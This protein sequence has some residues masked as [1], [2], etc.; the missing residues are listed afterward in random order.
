LDGLV[1]RISVA[2]DELRIRYPRLG[3]VDWLGGLFWGESVGASL[4]LHPGVAWE[5]V[6]HRGASRVDLDLR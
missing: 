4:V 2:A 1:P 3:I 6:F 5:L